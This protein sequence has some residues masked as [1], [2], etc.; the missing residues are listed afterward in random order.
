MNSE[1]FL[2]HKYF[3]KFMYLIFTLKFV[4]NKNTENTLFNPSP[5]PST[6]PT[7]KKIKKKSHIH[8]YMKIFVGLEILL[9]TS[10]YVTYMNSRHI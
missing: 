8:T 5:L 4:K 3:F 9:Y 7:K 10:V 1:Y 2:L 6:T